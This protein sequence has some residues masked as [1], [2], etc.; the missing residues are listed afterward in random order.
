MTRHLAMEGAPHNIRANAVSPG[1]VQ[2]N[3]T[4]AL[5][6]DPEWWSRM[7]AKIMLGRVGQPDDIAAAAAFLGSSDASWI[8]GVNLPV[9]GGTTAW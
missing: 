4:E 8:T 6:G 7:K 5:M 9:D 1:L 2:T 3:Q